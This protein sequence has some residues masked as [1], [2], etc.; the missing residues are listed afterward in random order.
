MTTRP[1]ARRPIAVLAACAAAL[2]AGAAAAA[3][4]PADPDAAERQFRLA[5]RLVAEGSPEAAPALDRVLELDPRGALADDALVHG[6]NREY[7]GTDR[8]TNVLSFALTDGAARHAAAA[9]PGPEMLGDVVLAYET[10]TREAREQGK[11]LH[12]HA[13]HLVVHGVL[14][15]IGYDHGSE[16]EARVMER[17]EQQ[18]LAELGIA[19]PYLD[20]PPPA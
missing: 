5:R 10:V 18:V 9:M 11:S 14:H 3:E 6:L 13:L 16:A 2:C 20:R 8:P 17:M 1:P 12:D 7:R 4:T 19:N 15:L